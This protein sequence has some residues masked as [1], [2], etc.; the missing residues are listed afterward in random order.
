MI[1]GILSDLNDCFG[2]TGQ[3]SKMSPLDNITVLNV[4]EN[5]CNIK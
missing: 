4:S 2:N 1:N 5:R 3:E